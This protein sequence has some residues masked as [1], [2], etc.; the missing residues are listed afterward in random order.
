M[1]LHP[2]ASAHDFQKWMK[3]HNKHF[4]PVETVRRRAIF[5]MNAR[6]VSEFNK[7]HKFQL[8]LDGPFAAMTN[9][10]YQKMLGKFE[11]SDAVAPAKR[12]MKAI[13]DAV[14]WR[15]KGKV[16][17]VRDQAQCGSCWAFSSLAAVETGLLI[18]GTSKYTADTLD[19][20]E[21]QLVDCS[22]NNGCN[23]GS[24]VVT[25]MYIKN[26][27]V[28]EE[29]DY[30]YTATNGTC[31]YDKT[32][33]VVTVTGHTNIKQKDEQ[34]LTNALAETAVAVAIDA[35]HPSFQLYKKGVYNEANC[36]QMVLNHGVTA[37]G[38]GATEEGEEYYIV[39]NS[40]GTS[41]GQAGYIYMSRN[42]NNQCGIASG[43]TYP[44]GVK[45]Y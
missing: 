41:W 24:L 42:K 34:D 31:K 20:S 7:N 32:K 45:E 3:M 23:G 38:Y 33:A 27:G 16:T 13:P 17:P 15:E 37:V 36:K 5:N 12:A 22:R 29:K 11:L 9:K 35:S 30:P 1:H 21:Q 18:A 25:M 44:T 19:L 4:S 10:E 43:A 28:E 6:F 26:K 14:D 40:W 2:L 39:K 8:S